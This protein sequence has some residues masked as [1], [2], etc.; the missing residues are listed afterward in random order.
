MSPL[1]AV[2]VH[3]CGRRALPV[4]LA[5]CC[6]C[7][8][9]ESPGALLFG[10]DERQGEMLRALG[11]KYGLLAVSLL[12]LSPLRWCVHMKTEPVPP[13]ELKAATEW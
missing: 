5:D 4:P 1:A 2:S 12:L 10:S 9:A 6:I 11:V 3:R 13:L 8:A 7:H